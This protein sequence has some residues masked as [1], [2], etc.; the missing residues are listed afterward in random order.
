MTTELRPNDEVPSERQL[1]MALDDF[2]VWVAKHESPPDAAPRVRLIEVV[3]MAR[4]TFYGICDSGQMWTAGM[5]SP[6]W[7][8]QQRRRV[9]WAM[10]GAAIVRLSDEFRAVSKAL[11]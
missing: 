11:G 5:R 1:R 7:A 8:W 9:L 6:Y 10:D 3:S 2:R 4:A